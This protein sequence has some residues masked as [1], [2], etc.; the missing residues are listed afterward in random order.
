[1]TNDKNASYIIPFAK[2][3]GKT[4]FSSLSIIKKTIGTKK[5]GHT[6]TLDSFADGL[7]VAVTGRMTRIASFI[8]AKEKKYEALISFGIETDTLDC[9]GKPIAEGNLPYY[10]D[11]LKVI[12]SF[13]GNISQ[14]PPQFSAL[15]IDGRRA[16]E[17]ARNGGI[18][19]LLPRN[20]IIKN[21]LVKNVLFEH[22]KTF[23][24]SMEAKGKENGF[25]KL[26]HI[27][28]ICGKGTYIRSLAKDIALFLGTKAHLKALRRLSIAS[29]VLEKAF[30]N[31]ILPPFLSEQAQNLNETK[32]SLDNYL[33]DFS[34]LL[35]NKLGF[36]FLELKEQ[37]ILS[38]LHGKE[39]K[40]YWFCNI[41]EKKDRLLLEKIAFVFSNEVFLGAI[42]L[43]SNEYKYRF[44]F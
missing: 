30:A 17:I 6:G 5:V 8:E 39:I 36:L 1:M 31:E 42:E 35:C 24:N 33:L 19:N 22:S 23:I 26:L 32:K 21:I 41:D 40:E 34:K 15:H 4:S 3:R 27:E 20:V 2:V 43:T 12:P 11:I 16:F 14:M 9:S 7:L 44:V 10:K 37:M 13:I 29:F 25:V 18:A 28:V 38:F